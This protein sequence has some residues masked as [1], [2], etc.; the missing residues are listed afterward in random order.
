MGGILFLKRQKKTELRQVAKILFS[1]GC[2]A[3]EAIYPLFFKYKFYFEIFNR[4]IDHQ[5]GNYLHFPVDTDAINQPFFTITVMDYLRD[6]F[7]Q[8]IEENNNKIR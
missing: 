6:L 5:N 7:I 1:G 2:V 3:D 4:I 8:Q